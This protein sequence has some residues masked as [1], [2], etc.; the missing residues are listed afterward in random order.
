M[1]PGYKTSE[2]WAVIVGSILTVLVPL[3]ILSQ[4]DANTIT[5]AL[6]YIAAV[7]SI[8]V[9]VVKMVL[10]YVRSRTA[11]KTAAGSVATLEVD[12]GE[13]EDTINRMLPGDSF[14]D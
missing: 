11:V 7:V 2:L 5:E 10:E 4:A 3:G 6:P 9:G 12:T 13:L 8:V 1:K 14:S